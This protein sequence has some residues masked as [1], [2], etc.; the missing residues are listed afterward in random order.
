MKKFYLQVYR[1]TLSTGQEDSW[2][3]AGSLG[4]HPDTALKL[5]ELGIIDVRLGQIPAGQAARVKK[6]M[7]L[8]RSLGV[9]LPGA[10]VILDLLERMER[11]QDEIERL[12][13]R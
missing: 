13:R 10:A 4:I 5:A 6:I 8:R 2:V 12:K 11:L 9:N 3:D 1:H 7:R